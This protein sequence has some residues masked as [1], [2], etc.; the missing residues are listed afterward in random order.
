[1]FWVELT[2]L[3]GLTLGKRTASTWL[4]L[5]LTQKV[6]RVRDVPT[7]KAWFRKTHASVFGLLSWPHRCWRSLKLRPVT[8]KRNAWSLRLWSVAAVLAEVK[9]TRPQDW[10]EP[11]ADCHSCPGHWPEPQAWDWPPQALS[12]A[13]SVAGC[14]LAAG[15]H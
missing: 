15:R 4:K 6:E 8:T 14:V 12:V 3:K 11:Q 10:R 13:G 2:L 5:P 7:E 1:M 9:S